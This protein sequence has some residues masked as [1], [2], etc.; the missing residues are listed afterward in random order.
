MALCAAVML[1]A[2]GPRATDHEQVSSRERLVIKVS[3]VV[4]VNTPK[5]EGA[6]RFAQA[7]KERSGGRVEVQVFPNSQLYKDGEEFAALR[8]GAVQL[9]APSTAKLVQLHPSWQVFDLPYLFRSFADVER[10]FTAPV[11]L[12]MRQALEEKGYVPLAIWPGGFKQLTNTHRPL[13]VPADFQG[14]RFRV[15]PSPVIVDQIQ[16]LGAHA[17]ATGFDSLYASL[18]RRE[19]DAQENTFS[20]IYTR[21]LHEVQPHLTISNHGYLAYVVLV[22]RTWWQGLAPDMR[23]IVRE[24]LAEATQLVRE[25]AAPMNEEAL[26]KLR[27]SGRAKVRTLSDVERHALRDALQPVYQKAAER[28]GK[29]FVDKVVST[30]RGEP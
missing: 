19:L 16:G 29:G 3:H 20:N 30:A 15:Q 27:H 13:V 9:I 28:L 17:T 26:S 25:R 2:C 5:G 23:E 1:A 14:L 6:L 11:G 10:L 7:M 24:S 22:D 21:H 18:E 12:E 8:E 4:G